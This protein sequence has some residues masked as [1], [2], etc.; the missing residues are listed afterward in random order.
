MSERKPWRPYTYT[1]NIVA[2]PDGRHFARGVAINVGGIVVRVEEVRG[3][4]LVVV[5]VSWWYRLRLWWRR[6]WRR[7]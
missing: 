5:P 1:E 2:V 6:L 3:N 4:D 7:S